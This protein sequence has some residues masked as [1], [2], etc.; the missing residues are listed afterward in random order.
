MTDETVNALDADDAI[1][2][3]LTAETAVAVEDP[4]PA[5]PE[6]TDAEVSTSDASDDA[7]TEAPEAAEQPSTAGTGDTVAPS[8]EEASL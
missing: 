1:E 7:P 4:A 6:T 8:L 5:A 3:E 2:P